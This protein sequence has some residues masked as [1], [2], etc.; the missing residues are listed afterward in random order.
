MANKDF[1]S[2]I[3]ILRSNYGLTMQDLGDQLGV[4]KNAVSMWEN[5]GVV[6]RD[7]ILMLISQKYNVSID[8]LLGNKINSEEHIENKKLSYIQRNLEQL[9]N[10]Q[11]SKA[12]KMLKVV[13]EDI[14]ND[15]EGE[16]D[17]L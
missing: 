7:D 1:S 4:T 2:A 11:L 10:K 15:D 13:F 8:K 12:E 16:D 14:F 6:P 17:E 5:K 9:D 3:K